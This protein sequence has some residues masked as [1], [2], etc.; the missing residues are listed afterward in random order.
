MKCT[1]CSTRPAVRYGGTSIGANVVG[2][3]C[4]G[5]S[6]GKGRPIRPLWLW[7]GTIVWRHWVLLRGGR[8]AATARLRAAVRRR[9][10]ELEDPGTVA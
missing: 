6:M 4:L 7:P 8:D 10:G 3:W 2:L 5:C 9:R 1:L